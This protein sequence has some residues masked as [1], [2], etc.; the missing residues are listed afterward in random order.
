[1]AV[2]GDEALKMSEVPETL[3][4][5]LKCAEGIL[6]IDGKFPMAVIIAAAKVRLWDM[7]AEVQN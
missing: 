7:S 6:G 3:L 2:S 4:E 1:M 5:M